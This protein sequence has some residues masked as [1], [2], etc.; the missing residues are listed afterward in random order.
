MTLERHGEMAPST[1]VVLAAARTRS[2]RGPSAGGLV[3]VAVVDSQLAKSAVLADLG[4]SVR[5]SSMTRRMPV[6][7]SRDTRSPA[8]V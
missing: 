5:N 1:R 6:I 2:D 8:C 4:E 7:A 3:R